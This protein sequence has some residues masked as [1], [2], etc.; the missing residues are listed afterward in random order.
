MFFLTSLSVC[1][2]FVY[3]HRDPHNYVITL[4]LPGERQQP[5]YSH[6]SVEPRQFS[7]F[8]HSFKAT[9]AYFFVTHWLPCFFPFC[10]LLWQFVWLLAYLCREINLKCQI[11]HCS[12]FSCLIKDNVCFHFPTTPGTSTGQVR[13][14]KKL[15]NNVITFYPWGGNVVKL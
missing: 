13:S 11:C 6:I 15:G 9:T 14:E 12:F 5:P 7:L 4:L 2:A 10:R 1:F 3:V 8:L